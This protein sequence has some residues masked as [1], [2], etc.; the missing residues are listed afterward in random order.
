M[1]AMSAA[2]TEYPLGHIIGYALWMANP[3]DSNVK[4]YF[5]YWRTSSDDSVANTNHFAGLVLFPSI[6]E[7]LDPISYKF[8]SENNKK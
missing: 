3:S 2:T 8:F 6:S 7:R 1:T 5:N 4:S